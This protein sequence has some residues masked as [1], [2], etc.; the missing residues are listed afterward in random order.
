MI[1]NV[2]AVTLNAWNLGCILTSTPDTRIHVHVMHA[3]V[4]LLFLPLFGLF[5]TVAFGRYF[6][7]V[8]RFSLCNFQTLF[9]MVK[10]TFFTN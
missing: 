9:L 7:F 4:F 8:N 3:S 5:A 6:L 10:I 2:C 1:C